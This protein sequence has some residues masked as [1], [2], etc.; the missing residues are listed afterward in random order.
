[1]GIALQ[2]QAPQGIGPVQHHQP[3]SGGGAVLYAVTQ[4][5]EKG[6]IPAAHVGNVI[7]QGVKFVQCLPGQPFGRFGIQTAHRQAAFPVDLILEQRSRGLV[8]PDAM[9]RSQQQP[10]ITAAL[11]HLH[12]G[13]VV[14]GAAGGAGQ[15]GHLLEH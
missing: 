12:G 3:L 1:M 7:N 8:S 5:G 14:R 15:Q 4:G 10:Q 13:T 9:L 2:Q 6:I 11:Q